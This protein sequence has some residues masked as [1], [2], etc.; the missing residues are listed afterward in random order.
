[1]LVV[2]PSSEVDGMD[3]NTQL[4]TCHV[5]KIIQHY[6]DPGSYFILLYYNQ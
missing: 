4:I 3:T 6:F 1:M 2:H 5:D